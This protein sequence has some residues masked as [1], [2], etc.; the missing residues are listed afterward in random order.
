MRLL[1][2]F[3]LDDE[4]GLGVDV[5]LRD[6]FARGILFLF[7]LP[8]GGSDHRNKHGQD[9]DGTKN[10]NRRGSRVSPSWLRTK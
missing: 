10:L 1:F 4:P 9:K 8:L 3:G 7:L 2:Y 6:L 5:D